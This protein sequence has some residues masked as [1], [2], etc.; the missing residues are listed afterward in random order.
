MEKRLWSFLAV[1][2]MAVS[3]AFAQKTVT[4]KV[5]DD[6]GEPVVGASVLVKGTTIGSATDLEGN[7]NIKNVPNSATTLMVSYI[8]MKTKEVTIKPNLKIILESD[9]KALNDVIVTAMGI[10]R[11]VKALGY[12]ATQVKA[13]EIIEARTNDIMSG[14]AGKIAG[15]QISTTSTDPG[16]SNS[17]IIRGISSLGGNQPL[18]VIDGVPLDN[19]THRS[20]DE[21]NNSFDFG[22]GAN[23]V[24]PE[25]VESMTVLKGAAA[26]ALYG[27]RAA[28]GVIMITTKSGKKASKGIGIEYNGGVQWESVLRVPQMQNQFGMGWYGD[29]TDDE[30]GSWGPAFDGSVLK[31]GSIY[32]NSQLIKSYSPV[33]NNI[34][35]F[36]DTGFRYNNSVSFNGASDD[37]RSNFFVSLSQL[38]ENGIIPTDADSYK[39]YTFSARGSHKYKDFTFSTSLNYAYQQNNFVSTGQKEGSMYNAIMQTPRDI[40][41]AELKD[42]SDPFNTP[43]YYYT[44]YGITNPYWLLENNQNEYE[45]ERFYGKLQ[46]DYDFLKYFKATY[47]FGLDTTTGHHN[48]GRPNMQSLFGQTYLGLNG[49]STFDGSTGSVSQQTNR[50]REIDQNFFVTYDQQIN[51]DWHVNAVAGVNGNERKYTYLSA[52]VTGLTIPTWYNLSNSSEIPTVDQYTRL[53][54]LI[55]GYFQGEVG[56]KDFLYLTVT[57]RN[58]W[59]ST[60]PKGNRSFFYPGITG[61]FVFSEL[62][63]PELKDIISFGKFRAAWGKTGNDATPYMVK[64]VYAQ[65]AASSTY[66]GVSNFPFTKTGTNAYTV[67]NTLGSNSLS[68]EMTS[69]VELGLNMAFLKN[70]L[71]FDFAFYN[72]V[73]DKQAVQLD[74]DPATGY[75]LQNTNFGKIRNRGLEL[76]VEGTPVKIGD[77]QWDLTFNWTKNWNKVLSLPEGAEGNEQ[78]IDAGFSGCE[79]Y[80]IEGREVGII[81]TYTNKKTEDGKVIVNSNGL[82]I[83]TDELVEIGSIQHKFQ[84][85]FGTRLRYKGVTLSVDFDYRHGGLMYSRTRDISLFTGNAIQTAYNNRNPWVVPNS[86]VEVGADADGNPIYEENTTPLTPTNIYNYWNNG[87][88][89]MD[90]DNLISKTYL[91]LRSLNL[92]WDLP[93]KWLART[94]LSDVRLTFF[95]TNLFVWTPSS[96]T[97]IDPEITSWGNDLAGGFGEYS[98]NPSSRKFGFNLQVKF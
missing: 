39:K 41:I 85:G 23:A 69:E 74:M 86:V 30:N 70:R 33:K 68:P 32:N 91:K 36:F 55:G 61:S 59:S 9:S 54:R 37:G 40:S 95:G 58:D 16:A 38:K 4:G 72:R 2:L 82:P 66:F 60:L 45:S 46:L 42:T 47:R 18:Y 88:L 25:D 81:K 96:N 20:G 19:T 35:D 13:D 52:A 15:V 8:G 6:L 29:K 83:T 34:K 89:G 92:S 51:D 75:T 79:L 22:N 10:K 64:S 73:T 12:S 53:R 80:A 21:L 11:S 3:M 49:A 93:K 63:K 56:Y 1:C 5:V 48:A 87:G 31:Y 97:F 57:A 26:T 24:N 50:N 90:A 76:L 62:L 78:A 7:F 98:A 94:F 84:M 28:A 43:G 65:G 77:F 44:P 17:V 14:L 71:S 27:S 67:G